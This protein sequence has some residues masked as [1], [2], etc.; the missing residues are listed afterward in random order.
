MH[1]Q[2]RIGALELGIVRFVHGEHGAIP[3]R[4]IFENRLDAAQLRIRNLR[5]I[6]FIFFLLL[7]SPGRSA[8]KKGSSPGVLGGSRKP[9][10][11]F[12]FPDFRPRVSSARSCLSGPGCTARQ[13]RD[14]AFIPSGHASGPA[15]STARS[16]GRQIEARTVV[17]AFF[18]KPRKI[19]R[20][21][22]G[23]RASAN[24]GHRLVPTGRASPAGNR[25]LPRLVPGSRCTAR[26][27]GGP[28]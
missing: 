11:L 15:S 23:I 17:L 7:R 18:G 8:L 19:R 22:L 25:I 12:D 1:V 26:H 3:Q 28:F 24:H 6:Q 9:D 21:R 13:S 14:S 27:P 4:Q 5:R 2:I 10:P 16:A 20:C